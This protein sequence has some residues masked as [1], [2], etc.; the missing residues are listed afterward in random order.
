MIKQVINSLV[1][2]RIINAALQEHPPPSTLEVAR[3]VG[4]SESKGLKQRFPEFHRQVT[5][6]REYRKQ[7]DEA[8]RNCFQAAMSEDPPPTVPEL[9]RRLGFIAGWSL[10]VNYPDLCH[11]LDARRPEYS[12]RRLA[13]MKPSSNRR[14][15]A[16]GAHTERTGQKMRLSVVFRAERIVSRNMSPIFR[17]I[18]GGTEGMARSRQGPITIGAR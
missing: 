14:A 6:R 13:Q 8:V 2:E 12:Q 16:T 3:R 7:H 5:R 4:Y 10:K 9:A 18:C 17:P 11:A 1:A 15:R